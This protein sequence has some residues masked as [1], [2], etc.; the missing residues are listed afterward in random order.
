MFGSVF[1]TAS[2]PEGHPVAALDAL[3]RVCSAVRLPVI[4]IGGITIDRVPHVV[5]AGAAGIA[6]IGLFATAQEW[7]LVAR[8]RSIRSAFSAT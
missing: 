5:R 3:T 7:E 2:K 6:A 1:T 4:A 8:V